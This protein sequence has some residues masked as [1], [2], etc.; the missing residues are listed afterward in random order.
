MCKKNRHVMSKNHTDGNPLTTEFTSASYVILHNLSN[1]YLF[2]RTCVTLFS[3]PPTPQMGGLSI[4][5]II[6]YEGFILPH[7]GSP[8]SYREGGVF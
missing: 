2:K 5:N 8:D 7:L 3:Y 4:T 1:I 6:A